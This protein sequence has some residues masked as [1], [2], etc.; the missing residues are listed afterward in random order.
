MADLVLGLDLGPNSIGWA[1]IESEFDSNGRRIAERRIVS[2]GVRVFEEGVERD[3]KGAEKSKNQTRRQA[4]GAR[5][6]H[7]RRAMRRDRLVR[8]LQGAGLLPV[9]SDAFEEIIRKDPYELRARALDEK[10]EPFEIGRVLLHINRR[11]GFKSNR[12]TQSSKEN[13]VV[14][15]SIRELE[16]DLQSAG[17]RTL[18]EYLNNLREARADSLLRGDLR[19]RGRYTRREM[20]EQEFD[21]IFETQSSCHPNLLT[22]SLRRVLRNEVIFFQRPLKPSDHLIGRC[23]LIPEEPRCP[24]S[25]WVAQHFRILKE[26]NS[27]RILLPTGNSQEL[28]DDQRRVIVEDLSSHSKRDFDQIRKVLGLSEDQ[29]FNLERGRRKSLRGNETESALVK[30]FGK[31]RWKE[32]DVSERVQ[33]RD[34]ITEIEDEEQLRELLSQFHVDP[35]SIDSLIA[36]EGQAGYLHL[37]EAAM[38]RL[39][40]YMEE[41]LDEYDART[42][43]GLTGEHSLPQSE[44]LPTPPDVRN[45]IVQRCLVECRKVVNALIREFKLPR[46]IVVELARDMKGSKS[47]REELLWEMR[48]REVEREEIRNRLIS[49]HRLISPSRADIER[50]RLWQDQDGICPY[51]GKTIPLVELY[52]PG[53]DVDHIFP[54]WRSLDDS[55]MNKVVCISGANREKGDRTPYEWREGTKDLDDMLLRVSKMRSMPFSKRRRFGQKEIQFDEFVS[56]QLNDTRYISKEVARYLLQL[57]PLERRQ[58]EMAV[59]VTRGQLTAELRRNWRLNNLIPDAFESAEKGPKNRSDHR[60]HA[61]DAIVCALSTRSHMKHY[62]DYLKRKHAGEHPPAPLPWLSLREDTAAVIDRIN[63]SHRPMRKISGALHRATY[64][65][66]TRDSGVYAARAKVADLS[67][68]DLAEIPDPVVRQSIE[69]HLR[70]K[71]WTEGASIPK[72]AL[73][74][75]K[76]PPRMPNGTQIKKVRLRRTIRDPVELRCHRTGSVVRVAERFNNHHLEVVRVLNKKGEWRL[77]GVVVSAIEAAR[78]VR[79]RDGAE[80]RP[81]VQR[82]HGEGTEFVMSLAR[83]DS[84]LATNPEGGNQVLCVIQA[85]SGAPSLGSGIDI[86]LR[87]AC[88]GRRASEGNRDPFARIQSYSRFGSLKIEKISVDAIGQIHPARD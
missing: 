21:A 71:G 41:G 73:N 25:K 29:R 34:A 10:L 30:A 55:Y 63:V 19:L 49:E 33:L 4:R 82:D 31:R 35:K 2:A 56:R 13:S 66:P 57:Y 85:I 69:D 22:E 43:S 81:I 51:T 52:A 1:L 64:Y 24:R 59:R 50:Y 16:N 7:Q 38:S 46:E 47:Q 36:F 67:T 62:A 18:G 20:Y 86:F 11:R 75:P 48:K 65:G 76:D 6:I 12:K 61:V 84:V 79:P 39:L 14:L 8:V 40:P 28:T 23:E 70:S 53:V 26:V 9:E 5:R 45:P 87:D 3:T 15:S 60:H 42:R 77:Q 54:R 88:D 44:F 37:S 32:F 17:A 27:L 72:G 78:R 80:W 58:G 68:K 74:D 83:G